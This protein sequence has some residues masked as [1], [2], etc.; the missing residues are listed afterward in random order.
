VLAVAEAETGEPSDFTE[1]EVV[2]LELVGFIALADLVRPT[3]AAAVDSVRRAG[4]DVAM[5]T[6]DHPST[7]EAIANELGILNGGRVLAGPELDGLSYS[8]FE[9][10]LADTTVFARI[11]PTQKVRIV[12]GY[13]R[14]GRVVAMTG[15]GAND[16]AAIRL[17][18]AGLALGRGGTPTARQAADLVVTD[19]RI[20]TIVD[21]IVEGR[22]MWTSVRDALAILVG[23]NLGEVGFALAASALTGSSPL[24]PR[25][26]LLVNLLTDMLPAL[27]IALRPPP[28]VDPEALLREGP[29][30]SLG[31]ALA[32]DIAL[33]AL[34]TAGGA[35]GAWVMARSTGPAARARTIGLVALVATQL[36][37][38]ALIGGRSPLVLGA[39]AVSAGVLAAIVQ[40]PGISQFFGCIPL[41]PIGW[42][43][44]LGPASVATGATVAVPWIAGR[45]G[46]HLPLP[47]RR[48][49]QPAE[50][51]PRLAAVLW[52]PD[53]DGIR[54]VR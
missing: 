53:A 39:C 37:Q 1:S 28:G 46:Y 50:P 42:A 17:A 30:A 6:G 48:A 24:T 23:G 9:A 5:V 34:A 4:V 11:T 33:R 44:A 16:A 51:E 18:D 35:T 32:R 27:A 36:G 20:E 47:R 8:E 10:A 54:T 31:A 15:D 13:Q 12:E 29:D 41:D 21:A 43:T 22:A 38:T 2:D 25:Q 7:A 26:L 45:G 14:A 40:T 3:A 52:D 19:D 49:V